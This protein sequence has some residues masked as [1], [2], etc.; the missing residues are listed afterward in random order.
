MTRR[1]TGSRPLGLSVALFA[2][3]PACDDDAGGSTDGSTSAASTSGSTTG[4]GTTGGAEDTGIETTPP[5]TSGS[6]DTGYETTPPMTSSGS[7]D[8]GYETTP[9]DT[10][11]TGD[12]DL[13]EGVTV[14]VT[15][16]FMAEL[17]GV[18]LDCT[19]A[20]TSTVDVFVYPADDPDL[21][22]FDLEDL[23][24]DNTAIAVG[25]LPHGDY[26]I[27]VVAWDPAL[28]QGTSASFTLDGSTSPYPLTVS[29]VEM[30]K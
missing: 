21:P 2:L 28:W 30:Q 24:C 8:T 6:E 17:A 18:P 7:E 26:E 11:S 19:S 13:D 5:M 29:L 14:D 9:P 23:P 25:P 15:Y 4:N 3:L 20:G 22:D 27:Q 10:S 16:E 1:F 12:T